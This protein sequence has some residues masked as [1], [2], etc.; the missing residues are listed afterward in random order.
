MEHEDLDAMEARLQRWRQ[1]LDELAA[2]APTLGPA[3][4]GAY[5]RDLAAAEREYHAAEHHLAEARKR[6]ALSWEEEDLQAA[7]VEVFDSIGKRIARL[8]H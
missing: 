5:E 1:Q 2:R 6:E 4:R 8:F 7:M 3:R